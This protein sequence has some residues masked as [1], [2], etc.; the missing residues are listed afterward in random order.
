[1]L[2]ARSVIL[3]GCLL[4]PALAQITPGN[5]VL[6]RVGTGS[7]A[8]SNASTAL[9]LDEYTLAGTFVQSVPLPTS[10][11]GLHKPVTS[12]G[13]ATSEGALTQSADGR[14]LLVAGY[15]TA[16]GGASVASS[17]SS[18]VP[19]V[20]ARIGLDEV[21]D[22]TTALSDAYSQNN[23]RGIASY[24]GLEFWTAGTASAANNPSVRFV[25][26]L[27]ASSSLQ[28]DTT[29]INIR[30]VDVW[31]NQV[32]AVT[33]S[34]S[35]FGV[36]AVGNGLPTTSPQSISLLPG[37][38][39]TSGPSPYDFWFANANT[40]YVA[41]D[42]T[43][44][45]GG[46]QKWALAAGVWTLQYTLSPGP[47]VGC[48]GL[49]GFTANGVTT[50]CATTTGNQ[51]VKAID[52]GAASL[53][54][55][56]AIGPANTAWRGLRF[57]RTPASL[58]FVGQPCSTTFGP[59]YIGAAGG[60]PVAGN[61]NFTLATDNTPPQALVLFSV[62]LGAVLPTGVALPGAQPCVLVHVFPDVLVAV[63]ADAFGSAQVGLP[64][65]NEGGLGGTQIGVQSLV[66]DAN[67]SAWALPFGS[68]DALQIV[69][70]N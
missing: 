49:S 57:V 46:I 51:L 63:I 39:T 58:T 7:A 17:S 69:I 23:F 22:S 36:C 61:S 35:A 14:F 41:D 47:G 55:S 33:A 13:T 40:L 50:L 27:G 11:N 64:I 31:N 20:C 42:R 45:L 12:S 2:R 4:S 30:R 3:F 6:L 53:V 24:S 32:W 8:L 59:P 25:A 16:P 26:G 43:T 70:G 34:G 21:I 48:R 29:S 38:P 68:S 56:L 19:R 37:F 62:K 1:M 10:A 54:Q 5:L 52:T 66:F 60:D 28:L 44:G 9:F 67:L 15:G 65:P 18:S